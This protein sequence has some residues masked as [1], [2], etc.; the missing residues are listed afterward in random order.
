L[1]EGKQ[2]DA[3]E[4]S[5]FPN[6]MR[7]TSVA[8]CIP[9]ILTP[10]L[11]PN[12]HRAR[13]SAYPLPTSYPH[14]LKHPSLGTQIRPTSTSVISSFSAGTHTAPL[15]RAYARLVDDVVRRRPDLGAIAAFERDE[16]LELASDLWTMHD[17]YAGEDVEADADADG[18]LGED[19]TI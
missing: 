3:Y 10:D 19:E 18:E 17:S 11:S 6:V 2:V 12:I 14:I 1:A 8:L 7:R 15:L 4:S 16:L 9:F 13:L 5:S